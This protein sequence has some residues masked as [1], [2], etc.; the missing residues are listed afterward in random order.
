MTTI[1]LICISWFVLAV[2][3]EVLGN[4]AFLFWLKKLGVRLTFGVRGMPGYLEYAYFNWCKS[5]G[6]SPVWILALRGVSFANL[7]LAAIIVIPM[8]ISANA[9]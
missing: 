2:V 1:Q 7:I 3:I 4:L 5:Q 8:I 6:R 9:K